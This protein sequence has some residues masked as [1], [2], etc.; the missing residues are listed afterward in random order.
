MI[1]DP[2]KVK[3]KIELRNELIKRGS[4]SAPPHQRR[5]LQSAAKTKKTS[6]GLEGRLAETEG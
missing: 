6:T 2:D 4:V 1:L 5:A 3:T